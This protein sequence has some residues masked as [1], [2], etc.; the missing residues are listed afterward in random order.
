MPRKLGLAKA[1]PNK[2]KV[3]LIAEEPEQAFEE[4]ESEAAASNPS[5]TNDTKDSVISSSAV[6]ESPG[7]LL[8]EEAADDYNFACEEAAAA[9]MV[10]I[11]ALAELKGEQ[12]LYE[13]KMKRWEAAERRKVRPSAI[14]QLEKL[15]KSEIQ[16][17]KARLKAMAAQLCAEEAESSAHACHVNVKTLEI[18][19]MRR[20]VRRYQKNVGSRARPRV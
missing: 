14:S 4:E 2:K 15:Y 9:D 1:R 12:R 7:K 11:E 3:V 18:N 20:E 6:C 19:R 17:L 5:A 8:R 16:L 13:A 10:T